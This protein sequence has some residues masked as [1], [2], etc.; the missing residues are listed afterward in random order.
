MCGEFRQVWN[1]IGA[2]R[3]IS[4]SARSQNVFSGLVG[5]CAVDNLSGLAWGIVMR[6]AWTRILSNMAEIDSAPSLNVVSRDKKSASVWQADVP[7]SFNPIWPRQKIWSSTTKYWQPYG[8]KGTCDRG[9]RS[10]CS[11]VTSFHL[12]VTSLH[13]IVTQIIPSSIIHCLI[14]LFLVRKTSLALVVRWLC[15]P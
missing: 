15:L 8:S 9:I 13:K 6:V 3:A 10:L 14:R 5:Q 4:V 1:K 11:L 7:T 12:R 2:S